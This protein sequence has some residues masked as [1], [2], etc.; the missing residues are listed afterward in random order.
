[1]CISSYIL[2]LSLL[3]L[4]SQGFLLSRSLQEAE[5]EDMLLAALNLGKI[6]QNGDKSTSRGAIPLLKHYKTE[7][8]SVFN[9][10][11]AGNMKVLDRGSRHDFFS[12]VKPINLGR[13]QLPYPALKGAMAFPADTE[14]QNIESIEER[15]TTDE[16]NS[17]KL[18]IGR[19]DFDI[20]RCMLGRVYRPCWQV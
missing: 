2:F 10:K 1:M 8:S 3:S 7:D 16:E 18:P 12:H 11:N 4:F 20:L 19:R 15:E 13:K 14:F 6:L 5:D 17:S 9:D